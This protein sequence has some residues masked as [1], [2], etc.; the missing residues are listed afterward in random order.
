MNAETEWQF[1]EQVPVTMYE[2]SYYAAWRRRWGEI[3]SPMLWSY[4]KHIILSCALGASPGKSDAG[5]Q[6]IA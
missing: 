2:L 1:P 5:S 4:A 6:R 3:A